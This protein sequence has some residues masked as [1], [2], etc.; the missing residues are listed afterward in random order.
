MANQKVYNIVINGIK[1]SINELDI[2][3]SFNVL[4]TCE[5]SIYSLFV[6]VVM[7]IVPNKSTTIDVKSAIMVIINL[8][9]NFL[10]IATHHLQILICNQ[11]F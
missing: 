1:E 8:I 11:H 9:S 10:N 6:F 7:Y 5:K 2:L 3:I 4:L